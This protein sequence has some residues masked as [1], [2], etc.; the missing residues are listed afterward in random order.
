MSLLIPPAL[1]REPNL[2]LPTKKARSRVKL[3]LNHPHT[4]SLF[5]GW[6]GENSE[7]LVELIRGTLI[8]QI[9]PTVDSEVTRDSIGKGWQS[10]SR[11]TH[12]GRFDIS[13][14]TSTS[15][16]YTFSFYAD[17]PSVDPNSPNATYFFDSQSGRLVLAESS[18]AANNLMMYDSTWRASNISIWSGR[19]ALLTV[20]LDKDNNGY[21]IYIDGEE[22]FSSSLYLTDRNIGGTTNLFSRYVTDGSALNPTDVK[23][24]YVMIHEKPLSPMQVA[25]MARKPLGMFLTL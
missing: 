6:F 1:V 4:P 3:D 2:F 10:T 5:C 25:S 17:W 19:Q 23:F 15:G 22:V 8:P 16:S 11:A 12:S 13:A 9:G 18:A 21:L 7:S 24:Y 20:V 14:Y